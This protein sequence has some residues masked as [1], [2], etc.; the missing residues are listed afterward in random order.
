MTGEELRERVVRRE[1][2]W[3]QVQAAGYLGDPAAL[4]ALR[5]AP[6]TL[7]PLEPPPPHAK[8]WLPKGWLSKGWRTWFQPRRR[9]GLVALEKWLRGLERWAPQTAVRAGH[10][11]GR[12][13]LRVWEEHSPL[14]PEPRAAVEALGSFLEAPSEGA[15]RAFEHKL[16]AARASVPS[17]PNLPPALASAQRLIALWLS[18]GF[19]EL[20]LAGLVEPTLAALEA[21][22]LERVAAAALAEA[23]AAGCTPYQ[24]WDAARAA[25][26]AERARVG[27]EP[28]EALLRAA[29]REALAPWVLS[30][31]C[32]LDRG[33]PLKE[34]RPQEL[35]AALSPASPQPGSGHAR[36]GR[37]RR[38]DDVGERLLASV[39]PLSAKALLWLALELEGRDEGPD[40]P[41]RGPLDDPDAQW[42]CPSCAS[43]NPNT[44]Y[45]CRRCRRRL[46]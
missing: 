39:L 10:A 46:T 7:P 42:A 9:P 33:A 5:R 11:G 38:P 41:E 23:E 4:E 35:R 16:Q 44:T 21:S 25:K 45:V 40:P 27:H 36:R 1:L 26:E 34:H 31:A 22:A 15:L 14:R 12:L 43:L 13:L 18:L 20:S 3:P 28:A 8:G 32:E 6:S 2:S 17:K 30:G 29:V 19:G 24:A 37:S